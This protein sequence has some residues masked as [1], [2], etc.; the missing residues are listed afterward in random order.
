MAANPVVHFELLGSDGSA[1]QKFYSDLFGWQIDANNPV[2]YGMVSAVEGGIAGG[3][4]PS[5]DGAPFVTVYIQVADLQAALD[6]IE[7]A[8]GKTDMPPMDVPGGP[9]IAMFTDPAGNHVGLVKG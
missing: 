2:N 6:Q 9:T 1:L 4:G 5:Q 7:K 3:V 8:G